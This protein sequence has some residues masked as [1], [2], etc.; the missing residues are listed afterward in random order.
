MSIKRAIISVSDKKGVVELAKGLKELGVE[1]LSTGGT[2]KTI[3]DAGIDAAEISDYT[4]SPEILDGRLKTLHPMVHG[5]ILGMRDNN[6]HQTEMDENNIR[7]IDMVVV[8]LY[9]FEATVSKQDCSLEDAIENIDI[10][11][12]TMI[13]AA[14]KNNRDV[15]VVVDPEDYTS[16]LNELKNNNGEISK[17]LKFNLAKKVFQHTARYDAAI[18]NYLSSLDTEGFP[19]VLTTQETKVQDLRYGENPHQKAVFY[20][21]TNIDEACVAN[22]VQLHGKE[23]SYNNIMDT[24]AAIEI[25]KEFADK[26]FV[27]IL[28]HTNPCGAATSET[29]LKDAFLKARAGDPISAFGG[30]VGLSREVDE[31]TAA[32]L[33][34]TFFEVIVAPS[35]SDSAL[36]ILQKKKN[37]RLL[38]LPG[39]SDVT[40]GKGFNTRKVIGGLLVQDR[41]LAEVELRTSNVPT[42]RKP[43]DEEYQGLDFAWKICKHVKSNAIVY[44]SNDQILGV[45]A[46]QMSR[47]DSARIAH[48]KMDEM[49]ER[50]KLSKDSKVIVCASDAFFPFRDGIDAA[51]KA[52][53]CAIVQPGGSKR[54]QEGI[55]AANEH[56][57]TMVFTGMRHFKH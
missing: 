44:T 34:E 49:F 5:G 10:G 25:T 2:A 6:K 53:A 43:T 21:D 36:Q 24:D 27:A 40:R 29:S 15:V 56:K 38:K 50:E 8:N 57:M 30:I 4:G 13:R 26:I 46:G 18:S 33:A 48:M 19:T 17:E 42:E 51:C 20:K 55:D 31:D 16:I 32:S 12:P 11:G 52:G 41:D 14:A 28:K 7:P 47:V 35:F 9:P 45:G 23:L 37:I 39:L 54:D 1:I 3:K 22:A